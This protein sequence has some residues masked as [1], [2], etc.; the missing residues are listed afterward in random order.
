VLKLGGVNC[1][2]SLKEA[3]NALRYQLNQQPAAGVPRFC[4][5][6]GCCKVSVVRMVTKAEIY[7]GLV[8][9]GSWMW[10]MCGW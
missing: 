5:L 7:V 8:H 4:R 9:H 3:H 1:H 6:R 10:V 2:W